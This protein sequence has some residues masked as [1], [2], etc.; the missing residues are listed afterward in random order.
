MINRCKEVNIVGNVEKL[1]EYKK[2][3]ESSTVSLS[4]YWGLF[5]CCIWISQQPQIKTIDLTFSVILMKIAF[6]V[7]PA[8]LLLSELI[9]TW[10][11]YKNTNY[12]SAETT[13]EFTEQS[14]ICKFDKCVENLKFKGFLKNFQVEHPILTLSIIGLIVNQIYFIDYY[15]RILDFFRHIPILNLFYPNWFSLIPLILLLVISKYVNYIKNNI[16]RRTMKVIVFVN[17]PVIFA[18]ILLGLFSI[19]LYPIINIITNPESISLIGIWI[20][21]I[22]NF[23]F[24]LGIP[25]VII[26]MLG[27]IT[28]KDINK[29]INKCMK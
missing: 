10:L 4:L 12:E 17:F 18:G 27:N 8:I 25:V 22:T 28:V 3:I 19:T 5:L 13:K 7:I 9:P 15:E 16:I 2:E 21:N 29:E 6:T 14:S 24:A 1:I 20:A 26:Y 11:R 23:F